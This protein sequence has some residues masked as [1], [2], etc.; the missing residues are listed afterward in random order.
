MFR[1][2]FN[3]L[4][5]KKVFVDNRRDR[6]KVEYSST[7]YSL[8]CLLVTFALFL[9]HW[10]KKPPKICIL[11]SRLRYQFSFNYLLSK[12]EISICIFCT[13]DSSI[14]SSVKS[15]VNN[16]MNI[17]NRWREKTWVSKVAIFIYSLTCI[18][19]WIF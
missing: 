6:A 9:S 19:V 4:S 14:F 13:Q 1:M 5:T 12:D 10:K 8:T 17:N 11:N 2:L 7:K 3:L 18:H 16:C 15:I